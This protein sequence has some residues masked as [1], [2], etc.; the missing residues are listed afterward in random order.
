MMWLDPPLGGVN[1]C[2]EVRSS[3]SDEIDQFL[4]DL[5]CRRPAKSVI[6]IGPQYCGGGMYLVETINTR[7]EPQRR[8]VAE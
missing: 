1:H 6:D 5:T 2:R 4:H 7:L 3:F 8:I